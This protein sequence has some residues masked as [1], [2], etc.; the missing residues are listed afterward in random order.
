MTSSVRH[1]NFFLKPGA[2]SVRGCYKRSCRS[3][4]PLPPRGKQSVLVTDLLCL[5]VSGG[6]DLHT[7]PPS[8]ELAHLIHATEI[9]GACV[10]SGPAARCGV[11]TIPGIPRWHGRGGC[12]RSGFTVESEVNATAGTHL[13]IWWAFRRCARITEI[14][15]NRFTT[16]P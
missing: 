12:R 11:L 4:A 14:G 3:A 9:W 13:E 8:S 5:N 6:V 16:G 1:E 10:T 7:K 2:A 15:L